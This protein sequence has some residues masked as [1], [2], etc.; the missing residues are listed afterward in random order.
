[1]KNKRVQI[2]WRYGLVSMLITLIAVLIVSHAVRTTIIDADKWNSKAD[3]TLSQVFVIQPKRGEIMA[4]DGSLLATNLT[5]YNICLDY[6]TSAKKQLQFI[7][8]LDSLCDSMAYYYPIRDKKQWK[9]YLA[10]PLE[11][12]PEKRKCAHVLLKE[13][14]YAD[15]LR[16][17]QFPFFRQFKKKYAHGLY[18][19]TKEVRVMPYGS[20][21]KRSIGRCNYQRVYRYQDTLKSN[22][23]DDALHGYSGIEASLDS[24]LYGKAGTARYVQLTHGVHSWVSDPPVNGA[25]VRTTID[26]NM[27]DIAETELQSMLQLTEADWGTC[28][29]M[30][31]STGDIKAISNL[32]RDKKGNYV[33]AMNYA[34]RGFEPGSVMKPIS[35]IV[36]LEDGYAFPL[37]KNYE[38]GHSYAYAGGSPIHDTHSPA[39][40]PV[41][42]FI[43]YSSNI[44]MTKLITPHYEH[45]LN[46]FRERLRQLGFFDKFD[47]GM[48]GESV[49]YFPTLD[50]KAGGRVS[51]SRM[52]YGYSTMIP[53]LYT[54]AIYNAI[55]NDGKFVRPRIVKEHITSDGDVVERPV[56]YV[57]EKICTPQNARILRKMIYDVVYG[58]GGTAKSLRND[59]VHVA[60]KT[61]TCRIANEVSRDSLRKNPS[62]KTGGYKEGQYRLAFCGFFPYEAPKYTCMV[63][64][65]HPSP[66]YRGAATTSGLVVKNIAMKMHARGMLNNSPVFLSDSISSDGTPV[67]YASLT[68]KQTQAQKFTGA[69]TSHRLKKPQPHSAGAV[70]D[71]HGLSVREAIARLEEAG[72]NVRI[73]GT[74]YVKSQSPAAGVPTKRNTTVNVRFSPN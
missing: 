10:K 5:A 55:A 62:A 3:S 40:L 7:E 2:I 33:E 64:I 27:Q 66:S 29:L 28:V 42:R 19:T 15:Y 45:D 46:G 73:H 24:I 38:I 20:M 57:R 37:E 47:T 41:S 69:Q 13:A 49:P 65:S 31:V 39:L 53:P 1:M 6:N 52:A 60:G 9:E 8:S 70:P 43:E 59:I 54:C 23:K 17:L 18:Y 61:G 34:L 22:V 21:A 36:A 16:I 58:E 63:L 67:L 72:Y 44:G 12:K 11:R 30:E 50:P 14:T 56:S 74:G 35:M 4:S 32:E 68:D 26:I 51:L 48:L 71:V 25:S